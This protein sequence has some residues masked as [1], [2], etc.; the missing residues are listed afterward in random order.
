MDWFALQPAIARANGIGIARDAPNPNAALLFYEYMLSA[1]AAQPG[2][3]AGRSGGHAGLGGKVAQ[4]LPR[5][6]R[7]AK[8]TVETVETVCVPQRRVA[9]LVCIDSQGETN[10]SQ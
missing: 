7:Q 3:Q 6:I 5:N 10:E 9:A 8:R 1:A 2:H 4:V